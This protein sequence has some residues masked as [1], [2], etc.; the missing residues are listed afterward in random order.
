MPQGFG[1]N[2]VNENFQIPILAGVTLPIAGGAPGALPILVDLYGVL[3]YADVTIR[4]E[5]AYAQLKGTIRKTI[6]AMLRTTGLGLS[7]GA[8]GIS[9]KRAGRVEYQP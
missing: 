3:S 7:L 1:S 9:V 5:R 2:T 6:E 4:I 8:P